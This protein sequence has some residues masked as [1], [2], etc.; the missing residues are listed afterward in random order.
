MSRGCVSSEKKL[1]CMCCCL[2]TYLKLGTPHTNTRDCFEECNGIHIDV[3]CVVFLFFG[4]GQLD[5]TGCAFAARC[6]G[7]T[8]ICSLDHRQ[9]NKF[10]CDNKK[11]KCPSN[12]LPIV[13]CHVFYG[14]C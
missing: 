12:L 7:E 10:Q 4:D 3:E 1:G 13:A 8:P 5:F 14:H 11:F 6:V 9:P 2:Y